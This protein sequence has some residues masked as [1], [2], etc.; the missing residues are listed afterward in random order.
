MITLE[1]LKAHALANPT[2]SFPLN[3][4]HTCLAADLTGGV[5]AGHSRVTL[6]A[7]RGDEDIDPKFA[8][9]TTIVSARGY[10]RASGDARTGQQIA[11]DIDRILAGRDPRDFV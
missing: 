4:C 8:R 2:K 9:Y 3:S 6:P 1:Q 11:D 7:G 5:M 10:N